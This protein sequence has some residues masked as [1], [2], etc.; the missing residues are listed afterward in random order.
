M[1]IVTAH[2]NM[3]LDALASTI[4]GTLLYPGAV[5]LVSRSV[6]P[7]VRA[8]LSIHKDLFDVRTPDDID[9]NRVRRLIVVDTSQW[10][11]LEGMQP[12]RR[13][14]DLE[15][16]VWDHHPDRGDI[17]ANQV[18]HEA[19]GA[20]ITLMIRQLR[21]NR[22]ELT[23]I[24]ATLFLAGLHEDTGNLMFPS[25]RPEDARAAAWLMEQNAD[26]AIV[27]S[28]LRPVYGEKQKDILFEMLQNENRIRVNGHSVS[29][30][31]LHLEGHVGNLSV[32]VHHCRD[33]LNADAVFGIF[34]GEK[35]GK[36]IVIGRSGVET[37]NIG[38]IMR[39]LGGGG[40]PGAG[41]AM[42]DFANP[43]TIESMIIDLIEGNQQS[44][45]QISDLM[46]FPVFTIPDH[47]PM[48]EVRT[49]LREKGISGAP[50]MAG[51]ELVGIISRR[52]FRKVKKSSGMNAPVKAF[53]NRDI[54]TISPG[55]SPMQAARL[56]VRHDIGR[57]PVVEDGSLIGIV[58]R[59]DTMRYFYDLLPE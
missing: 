36:T 28:L 38:T 51:D 11:R 24:Q 46:S 7:N 50:V 29:F 44:S 35:R 41:S 53:M 14:P 18:C 48:T 12:L 6:N 33:I 2:K 58:T 57:L 55:S 16:H 20:N 25:T 10:G 59:S 42:V 47:M 13:N 27:G 17:N 45:V 19:M 1:Q 40:H 39:S 49:V 43:D 4:A 31:K 34:T 32:V 22:I 9:L 56:M 21:Q 23:P 5:P 52:D 37:L 54:V 3:D 8:F 15:I 30:H 26:L